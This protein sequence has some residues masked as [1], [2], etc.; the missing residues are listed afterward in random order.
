MEKTTKHRLSKTDNTKKLQ[1]LSLHDKSFR[2][3][4]RAFS[5]LFSIFILLNACAKTAN[6]ENHSLAQFSAETNTLNIWWEKGLNLEEDEA[7]LGR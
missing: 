7:F 6:L 1:L 5:W 3:K 2:F 4:E